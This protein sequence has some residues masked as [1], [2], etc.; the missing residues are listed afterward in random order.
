MVERSE[1][2]PAIFSALRCVPPYNF[3]ADKEGGRRLVV[4][5]LGGRDF[6][7]IPFHFYQWLYLDDFL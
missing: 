5:P 7:L 4:P 2:F 3:L 1:S 6:S